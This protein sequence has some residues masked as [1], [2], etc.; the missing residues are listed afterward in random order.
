MD[1]PR[2]SPR[3][4][5]LC[6]LVVVGCARPAPTAL[7]S[8]SGAFSATTEISGSQ[9]T[10]ATRRHCV[11]L[12]VQD[13]Q[14]AREITFQTAA[15]NVHKWAIA[16]APSGALVL[17]SSDIGILAYD[18]D[19]GQIIERTAN[20]GESEAAREAYREKYGHAPRR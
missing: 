6:L 16:W 15:S 7:V 14:A 9:E 4:L 5:L 11:R 13:V 18:I 10:D 2:G 8:P 20:D 12:K 17:Y 19:A 3:L 1:K